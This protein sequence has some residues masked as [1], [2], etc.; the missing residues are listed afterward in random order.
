MEDNCLER[1]DL[2]EVV[3]PPELLPADELESGCPLYKDWIWAKPPDPL[4]AG[5]EPVDT[6]HSASTVAAIWGHFPIDPEEKIVYI[7]TGEIGPYFDATA[8]PGPN[9]YGSSIVALD[10]L[11]GDIKW[12][13]STSPHDLWDWDCGWGGVLSDKGDVLN[14]PPEHRTLFKACKN[15]YVYALDG[16]TGKPSWI[17]DPPILSK[18]RAI[19]DFQLLDP[20]SVEN[21]HRPWASCTAP[22]NP[23]PPP[24]P[25]LPF[26]LS[27]EYCPPT[28]FAAT[29]GLIESDL[30]YDR[31]NELLFVAAH[32]PLQAATIGGLM[33]YGNQGSSNR[34]WEIDP[35]RYP[36]TTEIYAINVKTGEMAWEEPYSI[37]DTG[38]R[39][40]LMVSGGVLYA[41]GGDGIL[42]M[43][44]ASDGTLLDT[45]TFSS[46]SVMPTMGR[47][48]QRGDLRLF[49]K[50]GGGGFLFGHRGNEYAPT[51]IHSYGLQPINPDRFG[52]DV[53][54]PRTNPPGCI[55]TPSGCDGRGRL[56]ISLILLG[57]VITAAAIMTSYAIWANK[58][59]PK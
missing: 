50:E 48:N 25:P 20:T 3:L 21:M 39:G 24:L 22:L 59:F 36:L 19:P 43:L 29:V 12:W 17:F 52:A 55:P 58:R 13:F 14:T 34:L 38:F 6:L 2:E 42:R 41:Y 1:N 33:H 18:I 8:R 7:G 37:P 45:L 51:L 10:V 15:G 5:S 49:V 9:L 32:T 40:G 30:A 28:Q 47:I 35:E 44:D 31:E 27:P 11:T 4:G 46:T 26:E 53:A 23:P 16:M 56:Y 54:G 57:A